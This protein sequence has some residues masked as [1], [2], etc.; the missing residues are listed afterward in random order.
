MLKPYSANKLAILSVVRRDHFRP[1]M[2]SPEVS[3]SRRFSMMEISSGALVPWE[4]APRVRLG[5]GRRRS[6]RHPAVA[7]VL[8]QLYEHPSAGSRP[9]VYR[10]RMTQLIPRGLFG[11]FCD[12]F[13]PCGPLLPVP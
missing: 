3:C 9:T 12:I 6:R 11:V 13:F 2:G 10:G 8:E 7:D 1:V 4:R 5:S